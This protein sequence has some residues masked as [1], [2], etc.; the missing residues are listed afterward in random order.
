MY[1]HR[2]FGWWIFQLQVNCFGLLSVWLCVKVGI[3]FSIFSQKPISFCYLYDW[4]EKL[5]DDWIA[6]KL[7]CDEDHWGCMKTTHLWKPLIGH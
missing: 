4:I 2:I 5:Q 7:F 3:P 6:A 1:I